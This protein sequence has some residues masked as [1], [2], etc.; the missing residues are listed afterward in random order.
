M[1]SSI[2]DNTSELFLKKLV[3]APLKDIFPSPECQGH[4]PDIYQLSKLYYSGSNIFFVR[5][6]SHLSELG[7]GI[8]LPPHSLVVP[9]ANSK[10]RPIVA[11]LYILEEKLHFIPSFCAEIGV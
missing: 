5:R 7:K 6:I 4:F 1:V 8:S 9:I 2:L 3:T 10:K 11:P